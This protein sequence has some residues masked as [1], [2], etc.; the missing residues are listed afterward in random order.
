MNYLPPINVP[1]ADPILIFTV[2]L[3]IIFLAP[4]LFRRFNIPGILGLLLAGVIIGPNGFN[5]LV[6]DSSIVLFGTVG[7]LYIMFLAGL[8][9]D[10]A[11]FKK[12][13]YRSLVF[14]LLTFLIPMSTGILAGIYLLDFSLTSSVLLASMFASHTLLS[15]PIISRLG[16]TKTESATVT[17]GGT[18]IANAL[19]LFIL[20]VIVAIEGGN[21][22]NIFW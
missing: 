5:L 19:S 13:K 8:E 4:I 22:N 18:L 2:I 1:F 3:L 17:F 14:G 20:S 15:Y 11:Q 9:I 21:L 10:L 6:R 7:L 16:I 12:R